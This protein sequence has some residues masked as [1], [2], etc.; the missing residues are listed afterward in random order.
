VLLFGGIRATSGPALGETWEFRGGNWTNLTPSAAPSAR[1]GFAFAWDPTIG[2]A[3]L[4][5]GCGSPA[6]DGGCGPKPAVSTWSFVGGNWSSVVT[7]LTPAEG[8]GEQLAYDPSDQVLVL[9]GA[10]ASTTES[11]TWSFG[12][13]GWNGGNASALPQENYSAVAYD[14]LLGGVVDFG[15]GIV[16]ST[17]LMEAPTNATWIY[18]AGVWRDLSPPLSPSDLTDASLVYYP[19]TDS[20]LLLGGES[21][22]EYFAGQATYDLYALNVTAVVEP[23]TGFAPLAVDLDANASGVRSVRL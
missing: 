7:D 10:S 22:D 23:T 2:A 21:A 9:I 19:P 20:F 13:D 17:G 16:R 6:A 4:F 1:Y 11:T 5:G 12:S 14:P 8:P 18:Q 3:L 15:G